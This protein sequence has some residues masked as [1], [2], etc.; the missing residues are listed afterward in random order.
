MNDALQRVGGTSEIFTESAFQRLYDLT[1]GIPRR[2]RQLAE[3]SL[4][5]GA[6]DGINQIEADAVDAVHQSLGIRNIT[7]AA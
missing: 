5:A 6:A 7:E 3:L 4:V 1:Q 2:V